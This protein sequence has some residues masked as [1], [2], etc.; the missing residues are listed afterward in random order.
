[1]SR[2]TRF[3]SICASLAIA[4]GAIA[5]PA[6]AETSNRGLYGAA[7]PTYDGVFRQS[8]AIMGLAGAGVRPAPDAV[9]WLLS[10]QCADGGFQ[11]YR[12]DVAAPCTPSDPANFA[13]EDTNSTATAL[14]ALMALN[15]NAAASDAVLD[16]ATNAAEKAFTWLRKKQSSDGGWAYYPG[17]QSDANSTGL[18]LSALQSIYP[19]GSTPKP[20]TR[21]FRYLGALTLPCTSATPGALPYQAGGAAN[22]SAS[23]QAF[24]GLTGSIPVRGPRTLR[25]GPTCG[26]SAKAKVGAYLSNQLTAH[27][28][29]PSALGAGEDDTSTAFA[30]LGFVAAG[31]GKAAVT[32]ATK[33]LAANART[34]TSSAA[35]P[36]A[37]GL[38]LMVAEATGRNPRA[39]GSLNLVTALQAA[40][41]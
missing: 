25:T 9:S 27:G 26:T 19:G 41:Q 3:L 11:A 24:I 28:A 35:G 7:D 20:L 8:L 34:Y 23:A 16:K 21:G 36:S 5:S 37:L 1:M 14:L 39:F 22:A 30:I 15:D 13:G 38:L 29:L 4:L 10:Q 32:K 31:T 6:Q 12:A 33:A 2:T 18:A 40:K 17:G